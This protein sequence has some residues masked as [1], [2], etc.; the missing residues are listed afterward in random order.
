M[1]NNKI[2][3]VDLKW[4]LEM[5]VKLAWLGFEKRNYFVHIIFCDSIK[6]TKIEFIA[7]NVGFVWSRCL[8]REC[9]A[10]F[11]PHSMSFTPLSLS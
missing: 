5:G 6:C 9:D 4:L 7:Q 3:I 11:V 8:S 2:L 1:A 10:D